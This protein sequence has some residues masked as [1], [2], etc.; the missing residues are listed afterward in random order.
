MKSTFVQDTLDEIEHHLAEARGLA[1]ELRR[2]P[3]ADQAGSLEKV[4]RRILYDRALYG[5]V[6]SIR[7]GYSAA[8]RAAEK[9][10]SRA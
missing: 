10:A 3:I 7:L 4:L 6:A 9:E 2:T 5:S 8:T 1:S